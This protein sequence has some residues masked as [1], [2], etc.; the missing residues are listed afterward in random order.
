MPIRPEVVILSPCP[1][2]VPPECVC[3]TQVVVDGT[4]EIPCQKPEFEQIIEFRV[5]AEVT[6][7]E[8]ITTPL[9]PKVIV[10][11]M[12]RIGVEYVANFPE[13]PMHFA[14]FDL[15]FHTFMLCPEAATTP[16]CSCFACVEFADFTPIDARQISKM[17]V[18]F[19]C[20]RECA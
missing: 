19:V 9:G 11:G 5:S 13:Q 7:C 10:S 14:H 8:T 6:N 16:V 12:V 20:A 17:V 1:P 4:I 15:P 2:T 18:L 3:S